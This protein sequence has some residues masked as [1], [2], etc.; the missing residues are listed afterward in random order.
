[1]GEDGLEQVE[2]RAPVFGA[3]RGQ[4]AGLRPAFAD[5]VH[6]GS[7][8]PPI[9]GDRF[10]VQRED[11]HFVGTRQALDQAHERRDHAVFA[12]AVHATRNDQRE[13]HAALRHRSSST[14]AYA[15]AHLRPTAANDSEASKCART[16][17]RG[18][19]FV[20]ATTSVS[21][22][23]T[24]SPRGYRCPMR[25]LSVSAGNAAMSVRTGVTPQATASVAA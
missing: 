3:D 19:L 13:F 2:R 25:P 24:G 20:A 15:S 11:V 21:A 7:G 16:R 5:V 9:A 18:V 1:T 17:S 8:Q 23:R 6:G 10:L 4:R 12:A 14:C 22:S